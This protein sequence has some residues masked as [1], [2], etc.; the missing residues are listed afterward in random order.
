[1]DLNDNQFTVLPKEIGKLKK[2]QTLD[3][4]NNQLTTLP[5]EIG[6]L[7]N[8]QWLYLQNNQLSLKEQERIR[9]LLPLKCKIIFEVY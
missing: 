9:K 5:T 3:L 2:L 7:Q 1:M 6:Q 8:L 4:R